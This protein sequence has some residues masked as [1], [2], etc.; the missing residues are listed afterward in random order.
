MNPRG[1]VLKP[2]ETQENIGCGVRG[3]E[4]RM[5]KQIDPLPPG[6]PRTSSFLG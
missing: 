4:A 3:L 5:F 1:F 2:C 6:I